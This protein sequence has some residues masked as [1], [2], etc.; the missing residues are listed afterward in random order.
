MNSSNRICTL[1]YGSGYDLAKDWKFKI[2]PYSEN[3]QFLAKYAYHFK[4]KTYDFYQ[5]FHKVISLPKNT[6]F[7]VRHVYVNKKKHKTFYILEIYYDKYDFKEIL[8]I[9][10]SQLRSMTVQGYDDYCNC[11]SDDEIEECYCGALQQTELKNKK[12]KDMEKDV[13]GDGDVEKNDDV[14]GEGDVEEYNRIFGKN[15][16]PMINDKKWKS[17]KFGKMFQY[18]NILEF[19]ITST[20]KYKFNLYS[21][22]MELAKHPLFTEKISNCSPFDARNKAWQREYIKLLCVHPNISYKFLKENFGLDQDIFSWTD[23]DP[24]NIQKIVN[25]IQCQHVGIAKKKEIFRLFVP[26]V[27]AVEMFPKA[28]WDWGE[29]SQNENLTDQFIEKNINEAW[30]WDAISKNKNIGQEFISRHSKKSWNWKFI[31]RN[32]NIDYSFVKKHILFRKIDTKYM[33]RHLNIFPFITNPM[34]TY[35]LIQHYAVNPYLTLDF[36]KQFPMDMWKN[37]FEE[38]YSNPAVTLEW[39]HYF[40][41]D[42]WIDVFYHL[43]QNESIQIEWIT[44]FPNAEWK[45]WDYISCNKGITDEFLEK[46]PNKPWNLKKLCRNSGISISCLEKWYKLKNVKYEIVRY[47]YPYSNPSM[48]EIPEK[49]DR[50]ISKMCQ[51]PNITF[52]FMERY[53]DKLDWKKISENKF[54]WLNKFFQK[55]KHRYLKSILNEISNIPYEIQKKII[56]F[57]I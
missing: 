11:S 13:E 30:N 44:F 54:T 18:Q 46:F 6:F 10:S 57:I 25:Y 51:H 5:F 42:H 19:I 34:K 23:N 39:I 38:L 7:E 41:F 27:K 55:R 15:Y 12:E 35:T 24:E 9:E 4:N 20:T 29:I 52:G 47:Q 2:W 8:K 1:D 48:Y 40:K 33:F 37:N 31:L 53:F 49:D 36:I 56:Q 26:I 28:N 22:Y 14:E 50:W 21:H 3:L 43:S 32:P 45:W 17:Y 16:Q